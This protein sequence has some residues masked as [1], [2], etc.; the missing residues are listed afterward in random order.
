MLLLFF[1][2]DSD[3]GNEDDEETVDATN[4]PTSMLGIHSFK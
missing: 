4:F 3:S 1:V 2:S